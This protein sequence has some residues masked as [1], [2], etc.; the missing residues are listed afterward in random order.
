MRKKRI[1]HLISMR[2][3]LHYGIQCA[4]ILGAQKITL[5]GCEAR[6]TKHSHHAQK[7]GM[8]QAYAKIQQKKKVFPKDGTVG[9]TYSI[10]HQTGKTKRFFQHRVGTELLT[11]AF[12][13]F[14]IEVRRYYH[15][16]GYE[17]IVL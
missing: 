15:K 17:D 6:T 11:E 7:R 12:A 8:H 10:D 3:I 16:K 1:C 13:P 5:V 4:A 2:S 9:I 14:G